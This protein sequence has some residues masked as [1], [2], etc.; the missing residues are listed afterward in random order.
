MMD[1]ILENEFDKG[2]K[3]IEYATEIKNLL[4]VAFILKNELE[5]ESSVEIIG[6]SEKNFELFGFSKL[7]L[8]KIL[9]RE[10]FKQILI[11]IKN[12]ALPD[13]YKEKYNYHQVISNAFESLDFLERLR[14]F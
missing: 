7:S 5:V 8:D 3:N 12:N 1:K 10:S 4:E 13:F 2:Y 9:I 14:N 11:N 6:K